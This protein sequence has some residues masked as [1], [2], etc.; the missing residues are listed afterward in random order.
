MHEKPQVTW[1]QPTQTVHYSEA[2][3][4]VTQKPIQQVVYQSAQTA[5]ETNSQVNVVPEYT[6]TVQQPQYVVQQTKPVVQIPSYKPIYQQV[7]QVP[8]STMTPLHVETFA[9][10]S[11]TTTAPVIQ[12][13]QPKPI[14]YYVNKPEMHAPV[15]QE[16]STNAVVQPQVIHHTVQKPVYITQPIYVQA[17]AQ[18]Q[19]QAQVQAQTLLQAQA[20]A[21]ANTQAQAQTQSNV[22]AQY[23]PY[24]PYVKPFVQS[25]S[26]AAAGVAACQTNM[27]ELA[28]QH[29]LA[30]GQ[31]EF[32]NSI[33]VD[34]QRKNEEL[35]NKIQILESGCLA[36]SAAAAAAEATV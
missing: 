35:R 27:Q 11:S 34:M 15:R 16:A 32:L 9:E 24:V 10:T 14:V 28:Y 5:A 36:N 22:H 30:V 6:S 1:Y 26:Q 13:T 18:A 19:V 25:Q 20:L 23:N 8:Q 7:Q 3:I 29:S 21:Q 31:V 17:P 33:I 4:P 12:Y 2:P